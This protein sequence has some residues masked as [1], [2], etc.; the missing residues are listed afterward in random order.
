M[1]K[2]ELLPVAA[3]LMGYQRLGVQV[4]SA[5]ER[6]VAWAKMAGRITINKADVVSLPV[7][8]NESKEPDTE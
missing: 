2:A 1:D 7:N 4:L 3:R 5:M 6:G 8:P